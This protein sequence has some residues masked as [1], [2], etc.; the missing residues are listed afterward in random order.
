MGCTRAEKSKSEDTRAATD[1]AV[2]VN[3]EKSGEEER[4]KK[5]VVVKSEMR[6]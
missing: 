6:T 5:K 3:S 1:G 2:R 4:R